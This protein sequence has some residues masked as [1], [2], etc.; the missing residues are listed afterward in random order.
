MPVKVK[1]SNCEN[2]S[3]LALQTEPLPPPFSD[4]GKFFLEC[5]NCHLRTGTHFVSPVLLQ[6]QVELSRAVARWNVKQDATTLSRLKRARQAYS[7]LFDNEQAKY[8]RF[9]ESLDSLEKA[10]AEHVSNS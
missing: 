3:E 10:V 7:I 9:L 8:K 2:T 4:V 6:E 1:C 5:P